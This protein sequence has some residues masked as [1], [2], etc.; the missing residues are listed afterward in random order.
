MK[1]T[2][3]SQ[4]SQMLLVPKSLQRIVILN[5]GLLRSRFLRLDGSKR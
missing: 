2:Q 5:I 4:I 1:V 3:I